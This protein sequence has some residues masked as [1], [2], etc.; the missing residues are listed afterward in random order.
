MLVTLIS[1]NL[2]QK[3]AY[4]IYQKI[5][6]RTISILALLT[7]EISDYRQEHSAQLFFV[8]PKNFKQVWSLSCL[9]REIHLFLRL[10][11]LHS[12]RKT[13]FNVLLARSFSHTEICEA[14]ATKIN[15]SL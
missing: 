2:T 14:A 12:G 13:R 6:L 1:G 15:T 8:P 9:R 11:A 4:N 3:V 7:D 5:L 10:G